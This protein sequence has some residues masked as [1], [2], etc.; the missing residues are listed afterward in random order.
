MMI[1][2]NILNI[3]RGIAE[4]ISIVAVS[5]GRSI[6]EIKEAVASGITDI[7]ENKVQEAMRKYYEL[8]NINR[9][10]VGHLQANKAKDAVEIFDLIQ[11]VDSLRLVEEIDKQACR[12]K[13]TQDI[14]IQVNTSGEKT[15]FG[16][17]PDDTIGVIEESLKFKNINIKG[18]MTIAPLVDNPEKARPYFRLL[19][20][21][22]D[23]I[24]ALHIT[25]NRLHILSMGMTDDFKIAITEGSNMV[26]LGRAIFE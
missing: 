17:K 10:L 15:K 25:H 2:E 24:N 16:L 9:H 5:K 14:L 13:K 12:I 19:R 6:E 26:R 23:K 8:R 3:K 1:K 21:L 18:L 4:A 22:R 20:E 7:G 11:S